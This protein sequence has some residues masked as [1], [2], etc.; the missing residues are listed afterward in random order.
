MEKDDFYLFELEN[1]LLWARILYY[2]LFDILRF[3]IPSAK[4]CAKMSPEA[5]LRPNSLFLFA[6]KLTKFPPDCKSILMSIATSCRIYFVSCQ[7]WFGA[8]AWYRR[9]SSSIE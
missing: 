5:A 6:W 2:S 1:L 9:L 7:Q 3:N 8:F 4:I